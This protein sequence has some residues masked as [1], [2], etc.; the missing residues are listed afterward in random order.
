[1]LA[2]AAATAGIKRINRDKGIKGIKR[3]FP[4]ISN[5]I[6]FPFFIA[7]RSAPYRH[8]APNRHD[9]NYRTGKQDLPDLQWLIQ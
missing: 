7:A 8:P 9:R 4:I 2:A 5:P 3:Y 1:M 6:E